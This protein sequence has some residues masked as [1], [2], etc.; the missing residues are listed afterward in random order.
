MMHVQSASMGKFLGS[1]GGSY[2]EAEQNNRH[3]QE[4]RQF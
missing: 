4:K 2:G 3:Y 1:R